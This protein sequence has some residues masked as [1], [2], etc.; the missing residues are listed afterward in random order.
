VAKRFENASTFLHV[1]DDPRERLLIEV[2]F[3]RIGD[4]NIK[5][6]QVADGEEA[7]AY[8]K[9]EGRFADS[10][11]FPLPGVILLDIKMP[12][13]SGFEF[14]KW[15]RVQSPPP[16]RLIPVVVISSSAEKKDIELAYAL[17]ANTYFIKPINWQEFLEALKAL[18]IY[19]AEYAA[20]PSR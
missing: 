5:L 12:R 9:R 7:I 13:V 19:W 2:A 10:L 11:K 1:D 8:L 16:C 6:I 18:G 15:L 14:L 3:D 17:G 20:S 4:P